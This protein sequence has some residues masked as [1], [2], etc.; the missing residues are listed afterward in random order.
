MRREWDIV[1]YLRQETTNQI[2]GWGLSGRGK[3]GGDYFLQAINGS[4]H[5]NKTQIYRTNCNCH[6]VCQWNCT[7][8]FTNSL[9]HILNGLQSD[10]EHV[11]VL[12]RTETWVETAARGTYMT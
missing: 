5:K 6:Q 4:S 12:I 7:F 8:F 3:A 10:S 9:S 2:S 11:L 1:C